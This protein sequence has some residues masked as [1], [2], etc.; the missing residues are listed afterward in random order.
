VRALVTGAA[1]GLAR[2]AALA[3]ARTGSYDRIAITFRT[4]SAERTLEELRSCGVGASAHRVDFLDAPEVVERVLADAVHADG[5]FDVLVH[6][7]GPMVIA[8]FERSTLDDYREMFDGNVRSAMLA[9]QA[10]LPV[11][12]E[13]HFGRIVVF[14]MN[15]SSV[16]RPAKGFSLHLAA[17]SALVAFARTLAL[18]E[19]VNGI[20]VNVVEPGDIRDK[21]STRA[22][23]RERTGGMPRGRSGSWEDVADAVLFFADPGNDFVTGAV[24][25]VN[26]GLQG[27]SGPRPES[28]D[29]K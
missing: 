25:A 2:G 26:G 15:G 20:T 22:Q 7:V 3:L 10:V 19:A 21:E 16:T 8:R 29:S 6:G 4:T 18:E 27:A 9:A 28:A 14:G 17:K 11:M 24:L 12:R 5:P 1:A 13:R 23:V